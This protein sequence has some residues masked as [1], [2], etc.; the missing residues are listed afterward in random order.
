MSRPVIQLNQVWENKLTGTQYM[1]IGKKKD[2]FRA[3]VL[4]EKPD[5]YA[6][7]HTFSRNTIW[8]KMK[9]MR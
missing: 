6:G 8:Q 9:L 7:S 5:V 1:V 3:V 2:K 4:T